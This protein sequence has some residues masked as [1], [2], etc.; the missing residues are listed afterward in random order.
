MQEIIKKQFLVYNKLNN[1]ISGD[2]YYPVEKRKIPAVIIMHGFKGY[3]DWGFFPYI[4]K[5][6]ANSG[7]ITL[8]FN[9]SYNGFVNGNN[10]LLDVD[11]FAQNTVSKE[12]E[13]ARAVIQAVN[14]GNIFR[15]SGIEK[16]WNGE[17]FLLGHSFGGA[18]SI[19]SMDFDNNINKLALWATI[20]KFDRYTDRQKR[21]WKNKGVMEFVNGSTGQLL[22]MNYS[23]VEDFEQNTGKFSLTNAICKITVPVLIVHGAQDLT[24][25]LKEGKTLADAGENGIVTFKIIRN[26][27]HLFGIEHPMKTATDAFNKVLL[28]TKQFFGLT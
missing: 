5:E 4:C 12:L 14:N 19:L 13:D 7:A 16:N 15:D 9:F 28:T 27:G 21:E 23:F 18:I 10:G 6:I 2:I 26:T 25:P 11:R 1:K 22:K 20:A 3:K 8:C 24:A 17:I